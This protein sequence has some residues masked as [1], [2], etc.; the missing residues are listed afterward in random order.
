MR[1]PSDMPRPGRG[2][3]RRTGRQGGSNRPRIILGIAIVAIVVLLL[4][5]RAIA[6]FWTDY[7]WF[8]SMG[9]SSVWSRLLSAR[10]TLGVATGLVFFLILWVNLVIADRLAPRFRSSVGAE[11][12]VLARYRE[13][14]AGRQRLVWLVVSL[15]IALVP[16]FSATSLWREWI[17]FRFGGDFGVDDPQFG[18]DVGF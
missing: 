2:G 11:E 1:Y 14:V 18:T 13:L 6:T 10:V 8:G 4:S 5:L 15:L 7:L 12:E 3:R 9:Q 16:A 17:L